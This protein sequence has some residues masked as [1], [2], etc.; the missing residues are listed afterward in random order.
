[1]TSEQ[2]LAAEAAEIQGEDEPIKKRSK[3]DVLKSPKGGKGP[4][5]GVAFQ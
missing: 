1:M 3:S 4:R 5:T 2:V